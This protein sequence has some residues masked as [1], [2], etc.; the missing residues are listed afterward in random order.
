MEQTFKTAKAWL[1]TM[2]GEKTAQRFDNHWC[3]IKVGEKL[4]RVNELGSNEYFIWPKVEESCGWGG[5]CGIF[6]TG[7]GISILSCDINLY[8][9]IAALVKGGAPVL[10]YKDTV[11]YDTS[12]RRILKMSVLCKEYPEG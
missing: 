9:E 5:G 1:V 8:R 2:L 4:N 7:T 11:W 10:A 3:A 12:D 6:H